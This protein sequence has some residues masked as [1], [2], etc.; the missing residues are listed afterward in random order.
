MFEKM[1]SAG[2]DFYEAFPNK[3][4]VDLKNGHA[5]YGTFKECVKFMYEKLLFNLDD[6]EV[7]VADMLDSDHNAIHFGIYGTMIYSFIKHVNVQPV[8]D[9]SKA[10]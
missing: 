8:S 7:A 4:V 5:F 10:S 1:T 3:W 2:L 9:E 6:I